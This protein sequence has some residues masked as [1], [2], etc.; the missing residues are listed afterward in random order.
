[1][2]RI[3]E[4]KKQRREY[5]KKKGTAYTKIGLA[6]VLVVPIPL[7]LCILFAFFIKILDLPSPAPDIDPLKFTVV[8][9]LLG[10]FTFACWRL[11]MFTRKTH[12]ETK[13]LPY[14]PPVTPATL[15]TEEILVRG[16]EEPTG[17][18]SEFLLRGA[19]GSAETPAGE[20]L[21]STDAPRPK[22]RI[23]T[24]SEARTTPRRPTG[25]TYC[26]AARNRRR[27]LSGRLDDDK[28]HEADL[29]PAETSHDRSLQT[30]SDRTVRRFQ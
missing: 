13:Q 18:Q 6:T 10:L 9:S 7:A 4:R 2:S 3:Q 30:G 11:V 12:Q 17:Q 27:Q 5:L 24:C 20:L 8:T 21:R 25:R 26:G 16:V 1:M 15:P 23:K 14:V 19:Q 28:R 22:I 29:Q